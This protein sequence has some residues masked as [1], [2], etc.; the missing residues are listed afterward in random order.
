VD[1]GLISEKILAD[2]LK[3]VNG[4][5]VR[6]IKGVIRM[7]NNKIRREIMISIIF[8]VVLSCFALI[9][10]AEAATTQL[11][12][13]EYDD[14]LPQIDAGNVAWEGFDGNDSEIFLY[15]G[16]NTIQLTNNEYNDGTPQ[17]DAGNVVWYGWDGNDSEVFLYDG[18]T[19]IQ[20]T[21]NEFYDGEPQIDAGNV[22]WIG[23]D[24][25]D[26]EVFL[27][28]GTNTI[29]LT[30]NEYD[31]GYPEYNIPRIDEG[32]V[33]WSVWHGSD[34]GIFLYDG[35][36][37]IQL[38]DS[39]NNMNV[40]IDAGN[41]VWSR[42]GEIFLYDG[43][44]TI[45]LT[46]NEYYNLHPQ[47]DAGNVM[48]N[49]WDGNDWE[50]FLYDGTNTIQLTDNEYDDGTIISGIT[51]DQIDA[52]NVV[53]FGWDG[54]DWEVFLY[55]GTNTIQLTDNEYND[56]FPQIDA[57]NVMWV[58]WDGNDAEI[59]IWSEDIFDFDLQVSPLSQTVR[60]VGNAIFTV[61]TVLLG[62]NPQNIDL[63][64]T[65][66]DSNGDPVPTI[67]SSISPAQVSPPS[68]STVFLDTAT[69]TPTGTYTIT[70]TG[71]SG[72]LQ[73]TTEV[74][75][76]I[77]GKPMN[78]NPISFS[79]YSVNLITGIPLTDEIKVPETE[80]FIIVL[81][82]GN[83]NSIIDNDATDD[84]KAIIQLI[85]DNY[86]KLYIR[87]AGGNKNAFMT[88][89]SPF[90]S[91][92]LME[93]TVVLQKTSPPTTVDLCSI[94]PY[95]LYIPAPASIVSDKSWVSPYYPSEG[96]PIRFTNSGAQNTKLMVVMQGG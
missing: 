24:W 71:T 11:T 75:L 41:V 10:S 63:D 55:D 64:V 59:F 43:T 74:T 26:S 38:T 67:K 82:D 53:W 68:T 17:I 95:T 19:T 65:V 61:D 96:V 20:L 29:Q 23:W 92:M 40:Q 79:D 70:V 7:V 89:E 4:K 91:G 57:G 51:A 73:K 77:E 27:Y 85:A 94:N 42:D 6:N 9:T 50:V 1:S 80:S 21:N 44:N 54:N 37:T 56:V 34:A 58:G 49:G 25:N 18:T 36:T 76:T 52:G 87:I 84:G 45:Q 39:E 93:D 5:L 28:D 62:G 78:D 8:S 47:I 15:D 69:N 3:N 90:T 30:D 32:K 46:D 2:L 66:K 22:V 35:T 13:N 86:Y 48:W 12:D 60:P 88:A 83:T 31:D 81:K 33:V 14:G 72:I 16:T